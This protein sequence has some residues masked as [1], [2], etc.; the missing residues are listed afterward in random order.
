M[1][2]GLVCTTLGQVFAGLSYRIWQ[3]YLSQGILFGLGVGC[4]FIP[5]I[6]ILGQWFNKRRALAFGIGTGGSGVGGLVFSITTRAAIE[7]IS[8]KWA[9]IIKCVFALPD[10]CSSA[11]HLT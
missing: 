5:A 7:N 1:T 11:R 9:Y 8:L 4:V 10:T 3:L 2:V 6:P